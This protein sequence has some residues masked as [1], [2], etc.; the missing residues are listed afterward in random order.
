MNITYHLVPKAYFES[1]NLEAGYLAARFAEE[2]FI[3]CTD[4]ELMLSRKAVQYY[5]QLQDELL[6][7]FIDCEKLK[8]PVR[9]DDPEQ[10]FPHIYGPI[11]RAAIVKISRMVRDRKGE[12]I[13]PI[14]ESTLSKV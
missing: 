2:G 3:H 7:L 6:I 8:S 14:S 4:G 9:Y 5:S 10:L 1:Q 11:N 13:F 12:W